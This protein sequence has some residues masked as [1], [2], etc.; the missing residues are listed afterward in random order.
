MDYWNIF[1]LAITLLSCGTIVLDGIGSLPLGGSM[2]VIR[3]FRISKI[4]RLIKKTK[5]LRHIFKTFIH[6][7]KPLTNIGS[8]LLLILYMYTIAG[9]IL[10]G[11]V[12]RNGKLTD[13]LN[14]ESFSAGALALFVV[15]TTDAWTEIALSCLKRQSVDFDCIQNPTYQDYVDNNRQTVGCGP[16]FSGILY[17]YSYF[18]AMSLILLKLFVAIICQAYEDIKV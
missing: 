1:D 11:Q 16:K 12:K 17:F 13:T 5:S 10:F 8:L 15:S 9:V 18:L 2:S 14:F 4:L 6:C 3:S 7:L